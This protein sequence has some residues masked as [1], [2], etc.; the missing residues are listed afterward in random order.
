MTNI[1]LG[2]AINLESYHITD[3]VWEPRRKPKQYPVQKEEVLMAQK[4][5]SKVSTSV[6]LDR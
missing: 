6:V 3:P 1:E 2:N 5:N 4:N